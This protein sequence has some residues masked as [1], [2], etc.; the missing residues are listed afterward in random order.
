MTLPTDHQNDDQMSRESYANYDG[1]NRRIFQLDESNFI[2]RGCSLRNTHYMYGIVVYTGLD[3]KIML[4]S[5]NARPKSS[6]LES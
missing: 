6:T 2:L 4:N 3:T 1:H 5:T